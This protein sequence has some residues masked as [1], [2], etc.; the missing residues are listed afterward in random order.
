MVSKATH[1]QAARRGSVVVLAVGA[2][3]AG[4]AS[5]AMAAEITGTTD[6]VT[7]A[8]DAAMYTAGAGFDNNLTVTQTATSIVFHHAPDAANNDPITTSLFGCTGTGSGDVTCTV[9]R[10]DIFSL[11]IDLGDGN[12]QTTF[13]GVDVHQIAESG[14]DGD[15]TLRSADAG[16]QMSMDGGLGAD[17]FIGGSGEETVSYAGRPTPVTATVNAGAGNDGVA[18]EGDTIGAGIDV[19]VGGLDGDSLTGDSAGQTLQGGPGDDVLNG[20]GGADQFFGGLGNDT[21]NATDA[22]ADDTVDCGDENPAV[23]NE[24]DVA[25][26]DTGDTVNDGLL[27]GL[28]THCETVTRTAIPTPPAGGGAGGSSSS[29]TTTPPAGDTATPPAGTAA[30]TPAVMP[31]AN[32]PSTTPGTTPVIKATLPT[33]ESLTAVLSPG[34]DRSKA[35]RFTIK[36][37]LGLPAGVT[38][39]K[40][41]SGTVT[42]TGTRGSKTLVTKTAS[43]KK[44]CSYKI[45]AT[46]KGKGK[47]RFSAKFAG[48]STLAAKSSP[49]RIG[50]AG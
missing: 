34:R 33:P 37:K 13:S 29:G 9:N 46:V 2:L 21:I 30:G 5:S 10:A 11:R 15:D 26:V 31:A 16:T 48:N 28:Q 41:C 23:T 4:G 39:A 20:G 40:G 19:V 3:L 49:V 35:Y 50:R 25:N 18:G 38:A 14:G 22:A 43:I 32:A 24:A 6:P 8:V 27:D 42:V 7:K 44:D 17:T 36:G 12:D 1:R 47:I 45:T